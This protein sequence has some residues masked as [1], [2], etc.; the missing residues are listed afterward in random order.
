LPQFFIR[1]N[2]EEE[3][4]TEAELELEAEFD[5]DEVIQTVEDA[6]S[7][8]IGATAKLRE[9][10]AEIAKLFSV[11]R[12][13]PDTKRGR[14][15]LE[16]ALVKAQ[17]E[18]KKQSDKLE[19]TKGDLVD[20]QSRAS[21]L[22]QKLTDKTKECERVKKEAA[23]ANLKENKK[24]KQLEMEL[25]DKVKEINQAQEVSSHIPIHPVNPEYFIESILLNIE[26]I[27]ELSMLQKIIRQLKSAAGL[28][29]YYS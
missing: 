19:K 25:V 21:Q 14:K 15:Q 11:Q 20:A 7:T 10:E 22:Q 26:F 8:A 4:L 9:I 5:F 24:T 29:I 1:Q 13:Y 23:N 18:V 6:L 16:Q 12:A 17:D 3:L 2:E 27:Q 28:N